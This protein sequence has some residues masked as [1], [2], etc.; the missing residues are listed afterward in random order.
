MKEVEHFT[1]GNQWRHRPAIMNCF[2]S[3]RN[4]RC[5]GFIKFHRVDFYSNKTKKL[6]DSFFKHHTTIIDQ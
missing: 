3:I 6:L 5:T 2:K 4:K 1:M